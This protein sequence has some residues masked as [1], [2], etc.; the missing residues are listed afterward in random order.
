M[1]IESDILGRVANFAFEY[2]NIYIK[3]FMKVLDLI[4]SRSKKWL[5]HEI[6]KYTT[7]DFNKV[8]VLGSWNSVLY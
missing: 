1:G 8:A 2:E 3:I 4:I 7:G 6:L 5:V